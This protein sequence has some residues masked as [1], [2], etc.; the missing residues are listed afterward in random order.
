M[1]FL[2]YAEIYPLDVEPGW[3]DGKA[4]LGEVRN[5]GKEFDAIMKNDKGETFVCGVVS[6]R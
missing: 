5:D 6:N 3:E 2:T 1:K 4:Q